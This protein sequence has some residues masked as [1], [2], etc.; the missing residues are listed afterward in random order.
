M[1]HIPPL[2]M[3]ARG[4]QSYSCT[5]IRRR[6][7]L[8]RNVNA[9]LRETYRCVA[10]DLIGMGGSGRPKGCQYR[11]ADHVVH[12][13]VRRAGPGPASSRQPGVGCDPRV[14]SCPP[15]T[16]YGLCD[17]V[18]RTCRWRPGMVRLSGLTAI[19]LSI[20]AWC[21]RLTPRVGREHLRRGH[22]M[23]CAAKFGAR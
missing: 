18:L 22:T 11:F 16:R 17:C 7:D 5:V 6:L 21:G 12:L 1:G 9:P 13:V 23:E 8:W 3:K 2:S 15:M 20:V 4:R 19:I 14:P 10:P